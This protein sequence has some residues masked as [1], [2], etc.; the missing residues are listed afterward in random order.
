MKAYISKLDLAIVL[1]TD[2][3]NADFITNE[4]E[5]LEVGSE[6]DINCIKAVLVDD[7]ITLIEDSEKV[8]AK[9]LAAKQL[10]ISAINAAMNADIN[11]QMFTTY[12]TTDRVTANAIQQSWA[13][14]A[15]APEVYVPAVF[16]SVE[17]AVAYITPK[18][19]A[20]R[21]FN[22]WRIGR[23]AQRDADIAAL[24]V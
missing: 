19:A 17:V 6:L 11:T 21:A 13:D 3:D 8:A 5:I 12:E 9:N 2:Q 22:I 16:P 10:Q 14:I 24:G 18:L 15:L 1:I 4:I 23:V 20:A 7:V